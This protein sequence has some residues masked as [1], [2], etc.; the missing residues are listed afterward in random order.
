MLV[1]E[2]IGKLNSYNMDAVIEF[3]CGDD[4]EIEMAESRNHL[5]A[6][7]GNTEKIILKI[8]S[9]PEEEPVLEPEIEPEDEPAPE[10]ED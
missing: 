7:E 5:I 1:K 2:F 10:N 3:G 4:F 6:D 8:V 9:K